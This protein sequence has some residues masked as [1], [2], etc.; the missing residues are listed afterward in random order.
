VAQH[1]RTTRGCFERSMKNA[2]ASSVLM[3]QDYL[4]IQIEFVRVLKLSG[5]TVIQRKQI[6]LNMTVE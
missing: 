6:T 2:T 1:E 4:E 3:N 5:D